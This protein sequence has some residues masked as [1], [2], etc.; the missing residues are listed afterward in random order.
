MFYTLKPEMFQMKNQED[1]RWTI[2]IILLLSIICFGLGLLFPLMQTGYGIGPITLRQEKIYLFTS[3]SYFFDRGEIFIGLLLLFFTIIF[4]FLKYIFLFYT[5]SGK[6][7][8][9]QSGLGTWLEI[10]NKWSMLDVFV[11]AVLILN[12]K[13]DSDIIISRL[14]S[15]TT[16]F[17]ISIVL[18]MTASFLTR[19]WLLPVNRG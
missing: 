11:V 18:M 9:P 15:G 13:F 17:A 19:R 10:I 7:V 5:L 12:M 6:I 14:E 3:F 4:P 1:R 16:L 8:P 2:I